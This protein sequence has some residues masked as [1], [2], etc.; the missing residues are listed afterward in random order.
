MAS[1]VQ[2]GFLTESLNNTVVTQARFDNVTVD[3]GDKSAGAPDMEADKTDI[4][5]DLYPNPANDFVTI[6]IP[7]IA[8]EVQVS[9]Y[10]ADGK[11]VHSGIV[12]QTFTQLDISCLKPGIYILRFDAEGEVATRRL[13]VY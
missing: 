2:V 9:V 12:T 5:I 6:K 8:S 7:E 1:T 11:M 10:S 4:R 3:A 13:I